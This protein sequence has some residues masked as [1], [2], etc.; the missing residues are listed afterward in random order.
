[1]VAAHEALEQRFSGMIAAHDALEQCVNSAPNISR[2]M[3]ENTSMWLAHDQRLADIKAALVALQ[4]RVSVALADSAIIDTSTPIMVEF[5]ARIAAVEDL[6]RHWDDDVDLHVDKHEILQQKVDTLLAAF[7][8]RCESIEAMVASIENFR[9]DDAKLLRQ[10]SDSLP[11]AGSLTRPYPLPL[12]DDVNEKTLNQFQVHILSI[13][14]QRFE[15]LEQLVPRIK[16]LEANIIYILP[17]I[18]GRFL[19]TDERL[20]AVER[21]CEHVF[22]PRLARI[23]QDN[24]TFSASC[25]NN[26]KKQLASSTIMA[27]TF[28]NFSMKNVSFEHAYP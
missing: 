9:E 3:S 7:D 22:Q 10:F 18:R 6:T 1:M 20:A 17:E 25:V 21:T 8:S 12:A 13:L 24:D 14:Q 11:P 28:L 16:V 23:E 26:L 19:K 15:R 5:D 2:H 4:A 27:G